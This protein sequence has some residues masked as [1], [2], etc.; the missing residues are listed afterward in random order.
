MRLSIKILTFLGLSF[1]IC[2]IGLYTFAFFSPKIELKSANQFSIYDDN[3]QLVFQGSGSQEWVSINDISP[4]LI[5]AVISTEDRN[6]YR[7]NGFDYLRIIGAFFSNFR[8]NNIVQGASTISQQYIKNMFLAFDQTW[9]RKIEEAFLTLK[10]EVHYSKD[11]ILEGYLNTIDYGNGNYG[12]GNA[13]RFYFNKNV[14]ELTLEEAIILAGI[15]KSPNNYNPVSNMDRAMNRARIVTEAM[16]T[17]NKLTE[18][19]ASN[20]FNSELEIYGQRNVN[21][22]RTLMYYQNSVIS[23]LRTITDIPASLLASG[24]IKIYT[25]L[26]IEAQTELENSIQRNMSGTDFQVASIIIEPKT[27]KIKALTGGYDYAVSQFNRATQASRMVGSTMKPLLYYAALE[28]NLVSSSTFLSEPTTFVFS[29]NKTYSP[30]NASDRYANRN[31]TM[32][33]AMA[34]SDNIYAVKTHL[35]LGEDVLVD[36]ARRMGIRTKLQPIP[37][38]ALGSNEI[39]MID[40]ARAY[41]TL[42][43][44]GFKNELHFISRVEDLQGKI[45][46]E[47]KSKTNLVLNQNYVYILNELMTTPYNS[48]FSDYST[49]TFLNFG[50]RLGR[51]YAIKTGTTPSDRWL[52]GYNP[53]LLMLVWNGSDDNSPLN[54]RA[55]DVSRT[56]WLETMEAILKDSGNNW[57]EKPENVVGVIQNSI[58]GELTADNRRAYVFYYL[59]GTEPRAAAVSNQRR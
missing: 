55:A 10:M 24:G 58:T 22:L 40:L 59:K 20:L 54:P 5:N 13:S 6:F 26:S 1:I 41:S 56:I 42:A 34:V 50:S 12:I 18:E 16:V 44:N 2:I 46:Y 28:N 15:P 39:S 57:Y 36:V 38:L 37:S 21:N 31:I 4:Y 52:V 9:S 3:E 27:G 49:P 32:A 7:H 19:K 25:N 43:S 23:E 53:D 29:N 45:L 51:K 33:T 11:E 35:F 8:A 47:K 17:N 14:G 48:A 30:S